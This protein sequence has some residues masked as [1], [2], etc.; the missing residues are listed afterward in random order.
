MQKLFNLDEFGWAFHLSNFF[1]IVFP[2][3]IIGVRKLRTPNAIT[4][5][6][7][8]FVVA[9]WVRRYLTVVPTLETT[10]LPIQDTRPEYVHYTATSVEWFLVFAGASTFILFAILI[11]KIINIIPISSYKFKS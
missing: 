9:I 11:P 10:L 6:S 3:L 5:M 4:A 1:G 7:L 2:I 8:F